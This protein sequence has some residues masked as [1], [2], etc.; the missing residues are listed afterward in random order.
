MVPKIFPR[1]ALAKILNRYRSR[2][3]IVFTNGCYDLLHVGH[4]RL[5]KKAKSLGD[6]LILA[7]NSD[8]SLR[9]LKGRGRPLVG[10]KERAEVLSALSCVDYVTIFP[11]D[12]PLETIQML[13]PDILIKGGDYEVSEIVGRN[14]VKKVVRFPLVKGFSTSGLIQKILRV[15]GK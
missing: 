7:I 5:L 1:L 12:T 11:E 8:L 6:I 15:Y 10:E 4:V 14:C 2:K 9:K 13:K 3:K